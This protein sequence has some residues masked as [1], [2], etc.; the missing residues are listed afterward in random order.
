MRKGINIL[1]TSTLH[2]QNPITKFRILTIV[3]RG[4]TFSSSSSHHDQ[5]M[6]SKVWESAEEA[7][8]DVV[9]SGQTLLVGGFG[10]S[11]V[12]GMSMSAYVYSMFL[13]ISLS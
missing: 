3:R 10:L 1:N 13:V 8:K 7:I 5:P 11:G 12:P 4:R 9:Q 6:K 2:H